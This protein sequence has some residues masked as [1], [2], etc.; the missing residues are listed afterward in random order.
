MG[1][2]GIFGNFVRQHF[3]KRFGGVVVGG[4]AYDGELLGE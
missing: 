2:D 1:L 3:A 4:K